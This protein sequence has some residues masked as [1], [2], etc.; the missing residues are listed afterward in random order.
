MLGR[1]PGRDWRGGC[2]PGLPRRHASGREHPA[3]RGNTSL[4]AARCSSPASGRGTIPGQRRL[5]GSARPTASRRAA[6]ATNCV[7]SPLRCG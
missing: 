2:A 5:R 1:Q 4:P 7:R 6:G 3:A